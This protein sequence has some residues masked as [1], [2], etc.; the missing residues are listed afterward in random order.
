MERIYLLAFL[1][2]S[3]SFFSQKIKGLFNEQKFPEIVALEKESANLTGEE[4]YY[5]G[6]AFFRQENDEKA[7][8]YYDKALKG[9]FNNAMLY[10]QKGLSEMFLKKYDDALINIDVAISKVPLAEFYIEKARIYHLKKDNSNE[11]KTYIEGLSKSREQDGWYLQLIENAG[12]FYYAETKEFSKSEKIY[13][14][15]IVKYPKEYKLYEKLIKALNA[16]NNI[17]EANKVFDKMK[18]LYSEKALPEEYMKF[19]NMSVDEFSWNNQWVNVHK[20]FE[21]PKQMLESLYIVYLIDKSGEK[22]ERKFNIE[23]TIQ[24][25]KQDPEFVICEETNEGHTTF[26]LG[27]KNDRFT[28]NEL[29]ESIKAILD[30]KSN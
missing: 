15:G 28:I 27:F 20:S 26:P 4:L 24:I 13:G 21:V 25:K 14:D 3:T 6:Y 7:I 17:L 19:K 11:E 29:R 1:S 2:L 23:K 5:L 8:E 22:V 10:F 12:N 18:K 30:R 9:G 16:Q